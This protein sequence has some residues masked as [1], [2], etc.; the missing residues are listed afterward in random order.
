MEGGPLRDAEAVLL[1]D[2]DECERAERDGVLEKS[3]GTDDDIRDAGLDGGEQSLLGDFVAVEYLIAPSEER[4]R[5]R[6]I[7]E[8]TGEGFEVLSGEDLGRC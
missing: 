6:S 3:V 2:D 7:S 4:E 8:E 1:I 5:V